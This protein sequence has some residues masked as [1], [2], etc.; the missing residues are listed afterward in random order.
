MVS[1]LKDF[2]NPKL[3]IYRRSQYRDYTAPMGW[4]MNAEQLMRWTLAGETR[5]TL[6]ATNPTWPDLESNPSRSGGKP[7][8]N[9]LSH[10]TPSPQYHSTVLV[11]WQKKDFQIQSPSTLFHYIGAM[12]RV[13]EPFNTVRL[14]WCHRRSSGTHQC[15]CISAMT[16]GLLEPISIIKNQFINTVN[17]FKSVG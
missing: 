9:R 15:Y 17:Y 13:M 5:S 16:D 12:R 11:P 7:A 14:Y 3:I 1:R 8:T 6:S 10:G 2:Q 4:L